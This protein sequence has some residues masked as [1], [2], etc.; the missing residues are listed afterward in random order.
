MVHVPGHRVAHATP[1]WFGPSH[2]SYVGRLP[3]RGG[4]R[5]SGAYNFGGAPLLAAGHPF[6]AGQGDPGRPYG[7]RWGSGFSTRISQ[8]I[9]RRGRRG[10]K[11]A[12]PNRS[13]DPLAWLYD[14]PQAVFVRKTKTAECARI[15][16]RYHARGPGAPTWTVMINQRISHGSAAS[17]SR[18]QAGGTAQTRCAW[19]PDGALPPTRADGAPVSQG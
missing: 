11:C 8:F 19:L 13:G 9:G 6:E 4:Q 5:S 15:M 14:R 12:P 1:G 3:E 10:V 16:L 2:G 18:S 17:A 7:L